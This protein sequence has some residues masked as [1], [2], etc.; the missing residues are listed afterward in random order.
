MY[1]DLNGLFAVLA[2]MPGVTP[3]K[4][5]HSLFSKFKDSFKELDKC[6]KY[7]DQV[8]KSGHRPSKITRVN[9]ARKYY[10]NLNG[11]FQCLVEG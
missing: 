8:I 7:Y 5:G 2:A 1:V 4:A 11:A 3:E 6:S 10:D 9:F